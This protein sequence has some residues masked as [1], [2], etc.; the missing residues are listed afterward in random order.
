MIKY[1]LSLDFGSTNTK[2]LIMKVDEDNIS[3][4]KK[5]YIVNNDVKKVEEYIDKVLNENNIDIKN[6]LEVVCCGSKSKLTENGFLGIKPYIVEEFDSI[7]YGILLPLNMKEALIASIGTGTCY[8][9]SDIKNVIHVSGSG[10]GG[11]PLTSVGRKIFDENNILKVVEMIENENL[12]DVDTYISDISGDKNYEGLGGTLTAS[13]LTKIDK[14]TSDKKFAL[15]IYNMICQNI[16]IEAILARNVIE[17]NKKLKKGSIP[18]I[19][20]GAV[21]DIPLIQKLLTNIATDLGESFIY[22]KNNMYTNAIGAYE[23]YLI[24]KRKNF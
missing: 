9:Y 15:G 21:V 1:I 8:I 19:M 12:K 14:N 17:E 24:N 11:G 3:V 7:S 2:Y 13:N 18:I 16:G 4:Y 10:L 23:Y 22:P 5:D 20:T 6:Q